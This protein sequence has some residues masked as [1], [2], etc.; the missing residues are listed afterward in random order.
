MTSWLRRDRQ[1]VA[2]S[3]GKRGP[4]LVVDAL[5][6]YYG[7]AHA[8][9]GV[10][11][12]IASGVTAIVGRNGMGKTTL[13]NAITGLL[14]ATGSVRLLG[15][16]ILGMAPHEVT[17]RGIAYVPQGRGLF[18]GL[19]NPFA[20]TRYHS[21]IVRRESLPA[22]LE[23]TAWTA[24]GEI[25]GLKHRHHETWGVQFHPESILTQQGLEL[26]RNFVGLCRAHVGAA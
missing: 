10:S 1:S 5:D 21:L 26:M 18:A 17:R 12:T 4:V 3:A 9:Q 7:R 16:E 19:E 13:C 22:E 15:E 11:F 2:A 23:V 25:M 20:A 14:R 6:V 24:E 8:L